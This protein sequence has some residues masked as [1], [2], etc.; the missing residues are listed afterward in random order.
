[1]RNFTA[2][3]NIA[4]TRMIQGYTREE[5]FAKTASV[6]ADLGLGMVDESRLAQELSGGQQQRLAFARAILPDFSIDS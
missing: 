4:I 1:M 3:E 5:A 2:Y 6:L